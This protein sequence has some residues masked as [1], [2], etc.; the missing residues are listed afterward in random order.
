MRRPDDKYLT[1]IPS[2]LSVKL[3]YLKQAAT[4]LDKALSH[5]IGS[6]TLHTEF[7]HSFNRKLKTQEQPWSEFPLF[8]L[9][10]ADKVQYNV[11]CC[12]CM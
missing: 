3:S 7:L 12:T 9:A 10:Y 4:E 1:T 5:A 11:Q 8:L 2:N 6:T